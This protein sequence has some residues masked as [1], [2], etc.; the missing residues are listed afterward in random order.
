MIENAAL[1]NS[2]AVSDTENMLTHG[3]NQRSLKTQETEERCIG[4]VCLC[5]VLDDRRCNDTSYVWQKRTSRDKCAS[6]ML[7][8]CSKNTTMDSSGC[9]EGLDAG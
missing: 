6:C 3:D 4:E 2:G 8:D 1:S 9:V 7:E 5:D